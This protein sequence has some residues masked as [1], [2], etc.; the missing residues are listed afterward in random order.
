MLAEIV[1][2]WTLLAGRPN[3]NQGEAARFRDGLGVREPI[4]AVIRDAHDSHKHGELS[5]RTAIHASSGQRPEPATKYGF[6]LNHTFLDGP[7]TPYQ[8]LVYIL[9]D[10]TEKSVPAMLHE[11]MAAWERELTRLGL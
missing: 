11:A 3:L 9:D 6:F 8:E 2:L 1:A 5:R 4:L 10:R 7:L